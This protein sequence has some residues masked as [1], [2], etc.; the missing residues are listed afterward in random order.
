M[1][2][3]RPKFWQIYSQPFQELGFFSSG[4]SAVMQMH[5]MSILYLAL[6]RLTLGILEDKG[7][8][9]KHEVHVTYYAG[10]DRA[11]FF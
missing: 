1:S 7:D 3:A 6:H 2:P 11:L 9:F 8:Q 5:H 10:N 4:F